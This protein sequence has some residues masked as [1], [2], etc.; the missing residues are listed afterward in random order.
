MK[1]NIISLEEFCA[2]NIMQGRTLTGLNHITT[3]IFTILPPSK[4]TFWLLDNVMYF[5][6]LPV[7]LRNYDLSDAIG[8]MDIF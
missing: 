6:Y 4:S 2:V 3:W 1:S 5:I 8:T 7:D